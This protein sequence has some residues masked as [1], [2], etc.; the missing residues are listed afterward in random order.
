MAEKKMTLEI[1]KA[2]GAEINKLGNGFQP[3][4]SFQIP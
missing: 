2:V 1:N 4:S 3:T